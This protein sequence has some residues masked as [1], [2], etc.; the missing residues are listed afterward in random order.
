[1]NKSLEHDN[2]NLSII[3]IVDLNYSTDLLFLRFHLENWPS[4]EY[5]ENNTK[6]DAAKATTAIMFISTKNA[7]KLIVI[8]VVFWQKWLF[9]TLF[10]Q[11][12][13]IMK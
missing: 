9:P 5:I 3:K 2:T 1:L 10:V 4:P 7:A 6:G 11:Y 8:C 12:E 13:Q